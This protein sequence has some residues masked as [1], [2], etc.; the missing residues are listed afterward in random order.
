MSLR[1]LA[2]KMQDS[3]V[4]LSHYYVSMYGLPGIMESNMLVKKVTIKPEGD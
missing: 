3:M 4:I 1:V 2:H